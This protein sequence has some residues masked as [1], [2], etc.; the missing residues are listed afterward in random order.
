MTMEDSYIYFELNNHRLKI[1]RENSEDIWVWYCESGGRPIKNPYW[2]KKY[3]S[4]KGNGY[5]QLGICCRNRLLHRIVYYAHNQDWDIDYEPC[6]NPIDHIDRDRGNNHISNLRLGT[7]SLNQQNRSNT[8]GYY[9]NK[10]KQK[11]KA[12][13]NINDKVIHL[14]YFKTEEE[15]RQAYLD[16]KKLYHKW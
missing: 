9:W 6:D 10:Q 8:K 13:I 3:I 11:Y 5:C 1:N 15:A 12:Y 14:G 2:K 16:A 7:P 4:K